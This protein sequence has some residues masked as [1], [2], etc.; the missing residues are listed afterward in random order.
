[1]RAKMTD[2]TAN[3]VRPKADIDGNCQVVKPKFHFH[4][5]ASDVYVCG[6]CV[7]CRIEECAIRPPSQNR[8]HFP[9]LM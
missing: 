6:F 3:L 2:Y 7:V 5:S 1:M 4:V 9:S 8:R